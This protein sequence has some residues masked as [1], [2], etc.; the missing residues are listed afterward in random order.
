[1]HIIRIIAHEVRRQTETTVELA[2][3]AP[4]ESSSLISLDSNS[5]QLIGERLVL[6]LG[7]GSGCVIVSVDE[8]RKAPFLLISSMLDA[9]DE[10]FITS[11]QSLAR[12]LSSAQI[13]GSIKSGLAL[14][15]QGS[16]ASGVV[17]WL[18]FWTLLAPKLETSG[19]LRT[20]YSCV[21]TDF[22]VTCQGFICD[23]KC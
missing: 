17:P 1:M 10:V 15:I 16:C 11:S 13:A 20:E 7:S 4:F 19:S 14:F 12:Q 22:I 5:Q 21:L 8:D 18:Y 6:A 2:E 23:I 3:R 9:E